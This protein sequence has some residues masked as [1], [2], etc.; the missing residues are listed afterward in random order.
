MH[1]IYNTHGATVLV[2]IPPAGFPAVELGLLFDR[3]LSSSSP[4]AIT[5]VTE[6]PVPL[7]RA[8][9]PTSRNVVPAARFGSH[10]NPMPI[11]PVGNVVIAPSG[12]TYDCPPGM[13]P[14]KFGVLTGSDVY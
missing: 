10:E 2:A 5:Y 1:N 9:P 6:P 13:R 3:Q 4:S 12:R 11:M 8:S 7:P 14:K